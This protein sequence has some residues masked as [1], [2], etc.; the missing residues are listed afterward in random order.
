M[1][2]RDL[3]ENLPLARSP[4]SIG[5]LDEP[6][7]I[8]NSNVFEGVQKHPKG[9]GGTQDKEAGLKAEE[10]RQKD[11]F[12]VTFENH[13]PISPQNWSRSFR[14]VITVIGG[15]FV[16]NSAFASVLPSQLLPAIGDHYGIDIEV[17]LLTISL[18]VAGYCVGPIFWGYVSIGS[19]LAGVGRECIAYEMI[20]LRPLSERYGRKIVF[21]GTIVPYLGCQIGCALSPNIGG[22]LVFRFLS[23][24]FAA[25]PQ[26]IV[27]GVLADIWNAEDR[28][29]PLCI[30]AWMVSAG[31]AFGPIISGALAVTGTDWRWAFW[32]LAILTVPFLLATIFI[33]PETFPPF[34][35]HKEA[36]RIRNTTGNNN[37]YTEWEKKIEAVTLRQILD[38]T[39]LKPFIMIVEEPMLL[40]LTM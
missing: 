29:N 33:I 4:T 34:L 6:D 40:L 12:L 24:C 3:S 9:N 7:K 16:F 23:G 17:A 5:T 13:A 28:A 27:G 38:Q 31:P 22:L 10:H 21:T 11:P 2:D 25:A 14:W 30:F 32:I 15:G 8:L 19:H 26:T 18:F 36:Q 37:Y 39:I 35:L 20:S 1:A